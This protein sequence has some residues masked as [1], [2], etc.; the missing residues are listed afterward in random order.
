MWATALYAGLRRGELAALRWADVDLERGLI[1]VERSCAARLLLFGRLQNPAPPPTLSRRM[2]R[3]S[4]LLVA[5]LLA[6][7]F[8]FPSTPTGVPGERER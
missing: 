1:R 5:V 3:P 8:S 2:K 7:D 6:L 4:L